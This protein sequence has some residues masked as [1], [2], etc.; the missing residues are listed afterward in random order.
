MADLSRDREQFA[1]NYLSRELH[2]LSQLV[3]CGPQE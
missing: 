2:L 3:L 1:L